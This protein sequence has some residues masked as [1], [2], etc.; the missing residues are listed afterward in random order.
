LGTHQVRMLKRAEE[1]L[2]LE[3]GLKPQE[4][5]LKVGL[6]LAT[7]YN[8]KA[9]YK[10][11]GQLAE[12]LQEKPRSGQPTRLSLQPRLSL[13]AWLVVRPGKGTASGLCA[14]WPTNGWNYPSSHRSPIKP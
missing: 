12:A 4:V 5:A 9:R 6:S 7:V 11:S 1:L 14:C 8:I 3:Q 10:E 2:G 13:Q